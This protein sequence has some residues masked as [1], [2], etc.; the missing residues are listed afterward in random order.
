MPQSQRRGKNRQPIEMEFENI[1][2][3][4]ISAFD[5]RFIAREH[6]PELGLD[7]AVLI[8][9]ANSHHQRRLPIQRRND[10]GIA[11]Q[12]ARDGARKA[13]ENEAGHRRE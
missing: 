9:V 8:F 10:Q 13:H 4:E 11:E 12:N 2:V 5:Q 7:H 1:K 3:A 6:D